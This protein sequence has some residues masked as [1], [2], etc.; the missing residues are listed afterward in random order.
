MKILKSFAFA[1]LAVASAQPLMACDICGC[2]DA[3]GQ[4]GLGMGPS[5]KYITEI[6]KGFIFGRQSKTITNSTDNLPTYTTG[7]ILWHLEQ[8]EAGTA[9]GVTAATADSDDNKRIITNS[10]GRLS[11]KDYDMY[12]ERLFRVTNN[13]SN[14]KLCLCGSGFLNTLN[15]MYKSKS[16]LN[17]DLPLTS[18]YGMK[19][20]AHVTPFGAVYYKTH[21][22][23]SLNAA[24][25]YNGLF[26]DVGNLKYRYVDGR[27]TE[28][29]TNRQ[30]NDADYRKDEWLTECGL[31][32]RY[33]ESHMYL[34]NVLDFAP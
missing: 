24:M 19:V 11:E 20:V 3:N 17:S 1:V 6:E 25:R 12:L 14:E 29:L 8:W 4:C 27:D 16:V 15:R 28:L 18:E 26:I 33:P 9:Y 21:P 22:L 5:S 2:F 23:F 30:P 13:K 34:Q 10:S 31:E 32:V 7:G